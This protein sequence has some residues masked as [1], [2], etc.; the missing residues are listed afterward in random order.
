MVARPKNEMI[1]GPGEECPTAIG[2]NIVSE[3]YNKSKNYLE[4]YISLMIFLM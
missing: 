1:P 2:W 3:T 4:S